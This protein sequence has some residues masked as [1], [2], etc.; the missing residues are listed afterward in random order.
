MRAPRQ[1]SVLVPS[2]NGLEHLQRCLPALESQDSPGVPWELVVLDNGSKDGSAEWVRCHCPKARVLS[3]DLNLGFAAGN[4]RL[5]DAAEGDALVF[6]N[7]DTRVGPSWLDSLVDA[8]AKAPDDVA[9]ISG[10]VHDWEGERLDFGRGILTF[11]GHAFQLDFGRPLAQAR[12]P[13]AGEELL[14]PSGGNMIIWRDAFLEV[15]GFDA[16]YFAYLEDVDLGWRLWSSGRRVL[17]APAALSYHRSMATS[18]L[19]GNANRGFLFE[20]NAFMTAYKNYEAGTWE[21]MMPAIMLTLLS[22]LETLTIQNNPGGELL[23]VD[24]YD[25]R[26]ANTGRPA[27][28]DGFRDPAALSRLERWTQM[29]PGQLFRAALSRLDTEPRGA[30]RSG[31]AVPQ[32]TDERTRAHHRAVWSL[33]AGLDRGA[34]KRARVQTLRRRSD[35]EIFARFPLYLVPTYPGDEDLFAGV[36]FR[37]WL[38]DE[39]P[40]VENTLQEIMEGHG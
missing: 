3:S 21:R 33:L 31:E 22:R 10:M 5:V 38:P 1:V 9:A 20:R 36:G 12:L 14:F 13:E 4:M 19:L 29:R 26:I 2:W 27:A 8:L 23:T 40:L 30:T 7:N 17:S 6:L 28:G 32:L 11:D 16:D 25:G 15:G 24:P 35:S 37:A 34:E 18:D 39:L